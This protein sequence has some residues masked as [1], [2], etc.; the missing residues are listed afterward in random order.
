MNSFRVETKNWRR[1][2]MT[3]QNYLDIENII[4]DSDLLEIAASCLALEE[5]FFEKS[6]LKSRVKEILARPEMHLESALYLVYHQAETKEKAT[7]L[8]KEMVKT[9]KKVLST[10]SI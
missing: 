8:L 2:E 3:E 10:Q 7:R 9:S 5:G 6:E 4:A 1:N